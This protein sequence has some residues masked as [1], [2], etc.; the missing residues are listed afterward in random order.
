MCAPPSEIVSID[1]EDVD[2]GTHWLC[3]V[4]VRHLLIELLRG[5]H[6]ARRIPVPPRSWS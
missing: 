5:R 6:V 2:V 3:K 4:E 1:A